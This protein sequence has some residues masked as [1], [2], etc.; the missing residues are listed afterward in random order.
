M[1]LRLGQCHPLDPWPETASSER[2]PTLREFAPLFL[3]HVKTNKKSYQSKR[4][5]ALSSARRGNG[6]VD[7][8]RHKLLIPL[9]LVVKSEHVALSSRG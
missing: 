1:A 9:V 8:V 3:D 6:G 2:T 4:F 5:L 7:V